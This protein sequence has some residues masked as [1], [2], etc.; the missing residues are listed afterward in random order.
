MPTFHFQKYTIKKHLHFHFLA[1][2]KI[3]LHMDKHLTLWRGICHLNSGLP[4]STYSLTT[5]QKICLEQI[6]HKLVR[7]PAWTE[8]G[9][10]HWVDKAMAASVGHSGVSTIADR[11]RTQTFPAWEYLNHSGMPCSP[12]KR[13]DWEGATSSQSWETENGKDKGLKKEWAWERL[14]Q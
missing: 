13:Q 10:W 11:G 9:S 2:R 3:S 14:I 5:L 6:T 8:M 12:E 7:Q 4:T 1:T